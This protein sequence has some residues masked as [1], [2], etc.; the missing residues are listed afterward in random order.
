VVNKLDEVMN[1]SKS[2]WIQIPCFNEE[3]NLPTVLSEL[4]RSLPGFQ[5]INVLV[6]ND[7]SSDRT[8]QVA[9]ENGI[10]HFVNFSQNR[11]L[12][13]AFQAGIDYCL[14]Q[15]A[16]IVVNTDADNQYPARYIEQLTTP[17]LNNEADVV[18]GDREPG[19]EKD[20]HPAKRLLQMVGTRLTSILCNANIKD[21]TSGF[22]AYSAEAATSIHI[23]NPYTY[24]LESLIQLS[25]QRFKI[26]HITI[27]KNQ[28]T[29]PSRLFKS[30]FSYIRKNGSVLLKSYIQFA[31]MKFFGFISFTFLLFG[32]LGT[33]P[34]I[35]SYIHDRNSDHF[36]SL[37]L[38]CVFYV[39][40]IQMLGFGLIGNAIHANRLVLE[41]KI[42]PATRVVNQ[43][44][45]G[46]TH[47]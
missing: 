9:K 19:T 5:S 24:T 28:T 11:G 47:F 3:E 7:G 21:A 32:V 43:T 45:P 20:F 40:S 36:Q 16:D 13:A 41:R 37:L 31:P 8:V 4:P 14:N 29:R 35:D 33:L 10:L 26:A 30:T 42:R 44:R 22:R 18:I 39:G 12:S 2:L 15:G 27:K 34:F 17:I 46:I 6:I 23:T 38:A 25:V 1:P